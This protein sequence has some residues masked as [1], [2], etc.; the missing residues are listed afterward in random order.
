MIKCK[1]LLIEISELQKYPYF[2]VRGQSTCPEYIR[3]NKLQS[4]NCLK[5]FRFLF[6]NI[7][8][9]FVTAKG[10]LDRSG[11]LSSLHHH[12]SKTIVAISSCSLIPNTTIL[13][14]LFYLYQKLLDSNLRNCSLKT[15]Q[16]HQRFNLIAEQLL[17]LR[18][19]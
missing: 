14:F 2:S 7:Y 6:N 12:I 1:F 9:L 19:N 4:V 11:G 18:M 8:Y 10:D 16:R 3:F 15:P 5:Y 13:N 17:L